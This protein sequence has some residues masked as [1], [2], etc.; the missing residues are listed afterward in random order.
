[1]TK[2]LAT[3]ILIVVFCAAPVL[4]EQTKPVSFAVKG[5][6]NPAFQEFEPDPENRDGNL[7]GFGGGATLGINLGPYFS[8]D[9]DLLYVRKGGKYEDRYRNGNEMD[10]EDRIFKSEIALDY[11]VVNPMIRIAPKTDGARPFLMAGPEFGF[12]MTAEWS[13]DNDM[14]KS[15]QDA[16]DDFKETD[17]GINFGAGLEIPT[18]SSTAFFVEG[19]YSLGMTDIVVETDVE[20]STTIKNRSIFIFGGIR[21]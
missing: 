13:F 20:N 21:F 10:G 18:N 7:M 9:T 11:V 14:G 1:M 16:K 8:I 2:I 19:R 17:F 3:V 4:A 5:G 12:L 15:T 6:I